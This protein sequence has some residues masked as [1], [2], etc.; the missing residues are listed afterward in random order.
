M[1]KG[2]DQMGPAAQPSLDPY[3]YAKFSPSL[4]IIVV[5]LIATLFFMGFFS[6]YIHHC[7]QGSANLNSVRMKGISQLT[8]AIGLMQ[9]GDG[10]VEEERRDGEA[11]GREKRRK[12][13]VV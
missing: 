4:A 2:D 6:I 5:V 7:S 12:K 13:K 8:V 1:S 9:I 3:Q 11:V 10:S